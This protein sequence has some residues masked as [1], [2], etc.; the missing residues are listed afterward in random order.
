MR[1]IFWSAAALALIST[2]CLA[3]GDGGIHHGFGGGL[4]FQAVLSGAQEVHQPD[5]KAIGHITVW[6][7]KAMSRVFV[8][9]RV[10]NLTGTFLAAHLHCNVA[11]ANGP[12]ALGLQGPGPL[13]FDGKGLRGMLTNENFSEA[14]CAAVVGRPVN[15]VAALAFAMRE[16]LVYVNVHTDFS[17]PGEIR[18]QLLEKRRAY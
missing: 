1:R 13:Q 8:D 2:P 4:Q 10:N 17:P 7:D 14:D 11:A 18:G 3:D 5:T 9:L 6:F 15:N 12:V 16:G